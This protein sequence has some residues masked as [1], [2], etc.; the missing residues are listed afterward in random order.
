M[1]QDIFVFGSNLRGI[2]GAGSAKFAMSHHGAVWG[3]GVGLHGDSY[4]IPTKDRKIESL[5]LNA[6]AKH[7]KEFLKFAAAHEEMRFNIVP[8]GCG[9]AGFTPEQIAPMFEG[10]PENCNLPEE[11]RKV[12]TSISK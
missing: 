8:I 4:A 1:P 6:V 11:F 5:P 2:H 10:A 12:L 7:V 3:K 9:L